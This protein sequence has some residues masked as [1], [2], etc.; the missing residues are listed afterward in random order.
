MATTS[1]SFSW[2]L[3]AVFVL[4]LDRH[5]LVSQRDIDHE[6]ERD[7]RPFRET[8]SLWLLR[9]GSSIEHWSGVLSEWSIGKSTD[10]YRIRPSGGTTV[11]IAILGVVSRTLT[12]W[13]PDDKLDML[14]LRITGTND[15]L[16]AQIGGSVTL[17][18]LTEGQLADDG[19]D[20]LRCALGLYVSGKLSE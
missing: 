13:R 14:Q 5:I 19:N 7:L 4:P 3:R 11:D 2:L 18:V 6:V 17:P 15:N 10:R 20:D 9:Q 12:I 8:P 1:D 16:Y